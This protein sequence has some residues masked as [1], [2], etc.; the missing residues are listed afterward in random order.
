MYWNAVDNFL[1]NALVRIMEDSLFIPFRLVGGTSLSLQFGHRKSVDID[2]FTDAAYGS[3]DFSVL[4][5]WF[6]KN[7]YLVDKSIVAET[8]PGKSYFMGNSPEFLFKTDIYYTEPFIR[9]TLLADGIRLAHQEDIIAMKLD[10]IGRGEGKG[11]RKKDFWDIHAAA[12]Y[13]TL[14]QMIG[15]YREK[16]PYG[17][18]DDQL[19]KGLTDF[20][21][22]DDDF[23]P[24]CLQ[25]K[26]WELIQF[27]F[28]NWVKRDIKENS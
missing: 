7:F 16:Y 12:E 26:H 3:I 28:I 19:W 17:A 11:G 23:D 10:I 24:V 13:Y 1:K 5:E 22:A 8:G 20:S 25:G 14:H 4:E 21:V 2:L 9:P 18:T 27:D 6:R 15:F